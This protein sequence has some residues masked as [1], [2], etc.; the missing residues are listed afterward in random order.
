MPTLGNRAR[1]PVLSIVSASVTGLG[2]YNNAA[3]PTLTVP[4]V[5][6]IESIAD[7]QMWAP[8]YVVDAVTVANN[9]ITFRIRSAHDAHSHAILFNANPAAQAVTMAADSLRNASAGALTVKADS[10]DGGINPATASITTIANQQAIEI[11][12][13]SVIAG[14]TY[15]ATVV[16]LP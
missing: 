9:V 3:R 13:G 5:R 7:V 14:V 10:A 1:V 2:A 6:L 8:G 16:G 12:N 4:N 11:P 15:Y